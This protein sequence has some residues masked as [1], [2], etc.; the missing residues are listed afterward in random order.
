M[1]SP[2][3]TTIV[4]AL[5]LRVQHMSSIRHGQRI[6]GAAGEMEIRSSRKKL[7]GRRL[8]LRTRQGLMLY[9]AL[10]SVNKKNVVEQ[11]VNYFEDHYSEKISLEQMAE[12]MYLSPF[13]LSKIFKS[14]TGDTPMSFRLFSWPGKERCHSAF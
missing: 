12:N 10:E 2:F 9:S 6:F 8:R 5:S 7:R 11:M 4:D 13:Y 14:E 3:I 1:A